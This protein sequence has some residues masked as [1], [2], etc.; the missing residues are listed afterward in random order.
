M[1]TNPNRKIIAGSAAARVLL[2]AASLV[3]VRALAET[4][5][6]TKTHTLFMGADIFVGR[7]K[8]LCAVKDVVGTSWV[9]DVNG[10]R[11]V[12]PVSEGPLNIKVTPTLKLTEVSA[13]VADFKNERGYS[14]V[15]DPNSRQAGSLMRMADLQAGYQAQYNQASFLNMQAQSDAAMGMNKPSSGNAG[16]LPAGANQ[17][18][19]NVLASTAQGAEV[20][21]NGPGSDFEQI[22]DRGLPAGFDAMEV[23][24]AVSSERPLN[25]PYVVTITRFHPKGSVPGQVQNLVY[26]KSLHPIDAHAQ[27]VHLVEGGFPAGFEVQ[28][29]QFHLYNHGEEIA[30]TVSSKRVS[31]TRDEAFEYVK[32]EYVGAHKG[33]TL[34]PSPAMGRLPP[35]MPKLLADGKYGETYYVRVSRDGTGSDVFLDPS[36]TQKVEDGYLQSIIRSIRFKPALEQGRPVDGVAALKL[37]QLPI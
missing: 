23:R 25:D 26:A 33:A 10:H 1:N 6:A 2:A 22:G 4:Q 18:V 17:P 28:D 5:D 19:L 12:I 16:H 35:E 20:A 15:N 11:K 14:D 32:M 34:P 9:V 21:A 8:E 30:T 27:T 24:F 37:G 36:C 29:F 31:L 13:T 3:A 7:G